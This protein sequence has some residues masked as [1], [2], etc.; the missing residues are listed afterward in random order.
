MSKYNMLIADDSE[1]NRAVL[2]KIFAPEYNISDVSDGSEAMEYIIKNG[3]TLN[4]VLL[5][6]Y[7]P[8]ADGFEVLKAMAQR[9][10]LDTVPVVIIT[11]YG[12]PENEELC[13]EMGA[14]DI[15]NKPFNAGTIVRRVRNV[16]QACQHRNKLKEIALSLENKLQRSLVNI[17]DTLS[18][19][20]EYRNLESGQ[21]IVRTRLYTK[22]LLRE[23]AAVNPAYGLTDEK[24]AAISSA[25][26][27]HDVGKIVIPDA[28]LNKPGR[29]TPDEFEIMKTHAAEGS[30]I[31]GHL[32]N[33]HHEEYLRYAHEIALCHHERWDGGGY[34]CGLAGGAIPLSAQV[35]GVVDVYDALTTKRVYKPAYSHDKAVEMIVNGE[36][37]VFSAEMMDCFLSAAPKFKV[38]GDRYSDDAE[39]NRLEVP[40]N[41]LNALWEASEGDAADISCGACFN[42]ALDKYGELFFRVDIPKGRVYFSNQDITS[43]SAAFSLSFEELDEILAPNVHSDDLYSIKKQTML[44]ESGI[45]CDALVFRWHNG[46]GA[47]KTVREETHIYKDSKGT[48][49]YALG[50]LSVTNE[51]R[52][53]V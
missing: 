28:I 45:G 13:L 30:A 42:D 4:V 29:L 19:I 16:V 51:C 37:G 47:F 44:I 25:A 31:V 48:G 39:E 7:M 17:I 32:G 3:K 12:N 23:V 20:I 8:K 15:I 2:H 41:N 21:H 5:D 53:G 46:G 9:K 10:L 27:L 52:G 40:A 35:T 43:F 38:L 33:D 6:I 26:A 34:P 24:I 18:T 11:G 36:C 50:V 14:C 1:L 22:I 49:R